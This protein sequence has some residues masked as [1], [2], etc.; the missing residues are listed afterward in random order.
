MTYISLKMAKALLHWE[1]PLDSLMMV[2]EMI[3]IS[4]EKKYY[5]L[6]RKDLLR[7]KSF[8]MEIQVS[9]RSDRKEVGC[10]KLKQ[11]MMI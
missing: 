7:H 8:V 4:G 5:M 1:S 2:V 9:R 6:E 10:S 3:F 11:L